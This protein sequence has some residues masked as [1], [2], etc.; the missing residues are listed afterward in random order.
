MNNPLE[1][2][3]CRPEQL[4]FLGQALQRP[5]CVLADEA[6]G[7]T[8][9]DLRGGVVRLHPDGSQQ[10]VA[11]P[12]PVP[13]TAPNGLAW[14]GPDH[15]LVANIGLG[16][17][18]RLGLDG[19]LQV[20]AE[21]IEGRPIGQINFVL[22][23]AGQRLWITVSTRQAHW[24]QAVRPGVADGYI[25]VCDQGQWRIVAD[26]LAFANEARFDAQQRWLY[27]AETCGPRISRFPVRPGG[28]LGARET[29]G[30][31]DHGAFIDGIAFDAHGNLW[32]THVHRDRLWALTPQ[33]DLRTLLD[34]GG[35]PQAHAEL[36]AAYRAGCLTEAHFAPCQGPWVPG[37]TSL[38]FGGPGRR[39]VYLGSL[40]GTR[41][42]CFESPVAGLPLQGL[43]ASRHRVSRGR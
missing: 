2:F 25:A 28:H 20:V 43:P 23:D 26:G 22:R 5:E 21:Q 39:T 16:R 4:R 18:E 1:G 24:L 19:R 11:P 13:G 35:P 41:I 29:F 14:D 8:V 3:T 34:A 40:G 31:E 38:A 42:A 15:L 17:L 30:P 27:V 12:D 6:G 33:G 10:V 37:L 36:M 7:L 32:G 9:S